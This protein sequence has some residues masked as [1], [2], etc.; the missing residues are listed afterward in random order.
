MKRTISLLSAEE[1]SQVLNI[2]E[3]TVKKLAKIKEL[4]C[5]YVN[6]QPRFD[7]QRLVK[8]FEKVEGGAA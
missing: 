7:F 2:S 4:P 1:L 8:H 3:F 6:K 5:V